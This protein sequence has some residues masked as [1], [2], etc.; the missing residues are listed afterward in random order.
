MNKN[1]LVKTK[2]FLS[3]FGNIG[4]K[5]AWHFRKENL[6]ERRDMIPVAL[7]L[8]KFSGRVYTRL[9]IT[10]KFKRIYKLVSLD[11]LLKIM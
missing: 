10:Y 11:S 3:N 1:M 6:E 9:N 5:L 2:L 7:M 8:L 4:L